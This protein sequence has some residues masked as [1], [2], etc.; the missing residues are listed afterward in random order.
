MNGEAHVRSYPLSGFRSNRKDQPRRQGPP[1]FGKRPV[2]FEDAGISAGTGNGLQLGA[3][4]YHIPEAGFKWELSDGL[5]GGEFGL[6]ASKVVLGAEAG[7]KA[8]FRPVRRA[9]RPTG[10]GRA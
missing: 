7:V 10:R 4:T 8:G 6:P 9:R 3:V 5:V 1:R 2:P